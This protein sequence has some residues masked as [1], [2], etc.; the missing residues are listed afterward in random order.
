MY[1]TMT[2]NVSSSNTKEEDEN[3]SIGTGDLNY[4]QLVL[5]KGGKTWS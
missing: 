3:T 5:T 2:S 4:C 1:T